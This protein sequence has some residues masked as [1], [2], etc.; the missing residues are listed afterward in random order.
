MGNGII[1]VTRFG[2]TLSFSLVN[3]GAFPVMRTGSVVPLSLSFLNYPNALR[4]YRCLFR[5]I[6][7]V[8]IIASSLPLTDIQFSR[9]GRAAS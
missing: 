5:I 8:Q 3:N 1:E 2:A 6:V 4:H 7:D 9:N